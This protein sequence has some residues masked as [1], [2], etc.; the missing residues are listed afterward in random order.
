MIDRNQKTLALLLGL[1]ITARILMFLLTGFTADDAYITCRFADNLAEG[2][3]MACNERA[4]GIQRYA[5]TDRRDRV[6][7][8]A[9]RAR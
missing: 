1:A 3:E 5:R 6:G 9:L 4:R 2:R 7:L 8:E